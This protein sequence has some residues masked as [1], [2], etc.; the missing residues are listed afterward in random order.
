MFYEYVIHVFR[1]TVAEDIRV[2]LVSSCTD[3]DTSLFQGVGA[4]Q[5]NGRRLCSFSDRSLEK[6]RLVLQCPSHSTNQATKLFLPP[7][8]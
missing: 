4:K 2:E 7:C 1:K 5:V 3:T 8:G 6:S